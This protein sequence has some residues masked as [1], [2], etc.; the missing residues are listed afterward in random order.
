MVALEG[1]YLFDQNITVALQTL[2]YVKC[3]VVQIKILRVLI[4]F[5]D[6]FLINLALL[7]CGSNFSF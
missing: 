1:N 7:C 3:W 4:L 5:A 6:A 2:M